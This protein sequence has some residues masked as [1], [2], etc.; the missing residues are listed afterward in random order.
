MSWISIAQIIVAAIVIT[1]ILLQEREAG[2]SGVFGGGGSSGFY[3][4]RRGV[5][6]IIFVSTV[7]GIILFTGLALANLILLQV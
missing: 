7:I 3:Q 4:T 5:E 2:V 1:L 6:K